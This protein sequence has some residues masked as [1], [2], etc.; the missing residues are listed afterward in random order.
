MKLRNIVPLSGTFMLT[1]LLGAVISIILTN[2]GRI[3]LPFGF[4][5]TVI[6]LVMVIASMISMTYAPT[7]F[8]KK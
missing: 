3:P 2:S 1:G 6:F 7:G 5:F 4:A 8:M